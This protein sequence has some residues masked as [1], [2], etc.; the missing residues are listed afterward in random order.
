LNGLPSPSRPGRCLRSV[1]VLTLA[2]AACGDDGG[3]R[4]TPGRDAD[5]PFDAAHAPADGGHDAQGDADGP[6]AGSVTM[7]DDS[8]ALVLPLRPRS[9]IAMTYVPQLVEGEGAPRLGG[10][11]YVP[12]AFGEGYPQTVSLVPGGS[13]VYA[14]CGRLTGQLT[15]RE[16]TGGSAAFEAQLSNGVVQV[17][18]RSEGDADFRLAGEYTATSEEACPFSPGAKIPVLIELHL[19][20]VRPAG[21]QVARPPQCAQASIPRVAVSSSLGDVAVQLLDAAGQPFHARNV[22]PGAPSDLRVHGARVAVPSSAASA[23][24]DL[25]ARSEPGPITLETLGTTM[26][27]EAFDAAQVSQIDVEFQLGGF[28]GNAVTLTDGMSLTGANRSANRIAPVVTSARVGSD[29][30]CSP[31]RSDWFELVSL[32]PETCEVV[33]LADDGAYVFGRIPL[34]FAGR[35]RSDGRCALKLRSE[36]LNGMGYEKS[37]AV[38]VTQSSFLKE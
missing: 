23:L 11:E 18:T 26:R 32:T 29:V 36:R 22:D 16:L 7:Q 4:E 31:L 14:T 2:V 10:M 20:A 34:A 21:A 12:L 24:D 3:T 27:I 28:A 9:Q 1:V 37:L 5:V 8:G 17:T 38:T 30:V 35:M 6:D 19:R 13:S 33:P 15:L 25:V